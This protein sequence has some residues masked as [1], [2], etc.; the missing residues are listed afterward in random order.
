MVFCSYLSFSNLGYISSLNENGGTINK[1]WNFSKYQ[2]GNSWTNNKLRKGVQ[3]SF[4]VF[5]EVVRNVEVIESCWDDEVVDERQFVDKMLGSY[6]TGTRTIIGNVVQVRDGVV[7]VDIG[8]KD[9]ISIVLKDH[10]PSIGFE[11]FVADVLN[12]NC[13]IQEDPES[14]NSMTN[15]FG[16][17]LSVKS[18]SPTRFKS[19]IGMLSSICKND[20]CYIIDDHIIASESV[21]EQ[22]LPNGLEYCE[23]Y[24]YEAIE[25]SVMVKGKN[26][27]WRLTKVSR[28]NSQEQNDPGVKLF[29][30]CFNLYESKSEIIKFISVYNESRKSIVIR[31][32][33][34][35]QFSSGIVRLQKTIKDQVIKPSEKYNIYLVITPSKS[36][37]FNE[38]L[39][40]DFGDF[41]KKTYCQIDISM[42]RTMAG[43]VARTQGELIPGQRLRRGPRFI[44]IRIESHPIPS[45]FS[46]YDFKKQKQLVIADLQESHYGFIFDP[47]EITNYIK[48]MEYS[49]YMEELEMEIHFERYQIDRGYFERAADDMFKLEVLDVA[50]KRPSIGLGDWINVIN[51]DAVDSKS[52]NYQGYIHKVDQHHIYVKFQDSFLREC[53]KDFKIEFHFSRSHFRRQH[54]ALQVVTSNRGLNF[55]FLFPSNNNA[56]K[57]P[58]VDVTLVEGKMISN[59]ENLK[60]INE[61]LNIYQKQAVVNVLRGECRPLPYIIYGPPGD[62]EIYFFFYFP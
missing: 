25:T 58:Q 60:W 40:V 42:K 44:A 39:D 43:Q 15:S 53:G 7:S 26:Y 19:G 33:E 23:N 57:N 17:V 30:Q 27:D 50:E 62:D 32:C 54:H 59:G 5:E 38:F 14:W 9:P 16:K 3:V 28:A 56:C 52:Y 18:F 34:L 21:V 4:I 55:D 6:E 8:E 51:V 24:E 41:K 1:I 11:L 10:H 46:K 13:L 48:K 31:S 47:L 29:G 45:D 20:Q 12:L 61:N 35:T 2:A 37:S 49:L 22:T 36:G